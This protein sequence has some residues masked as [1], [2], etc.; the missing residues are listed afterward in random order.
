MMLLYDHA[1][2]GGP[3]PISVL[4]VNLTYGLVYS[5]LNSVFFFSANLLSKFIPKNGI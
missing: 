1:Y 5:F 2:D 4:Y 3:G